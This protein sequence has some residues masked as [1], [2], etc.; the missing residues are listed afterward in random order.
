[1]AIDIG[2]VDIDLIVVEKC[3]DVV[4]VSVID[5]VEHDVVSDLFD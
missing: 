4:D 1:M 3:D 5:G 2:A